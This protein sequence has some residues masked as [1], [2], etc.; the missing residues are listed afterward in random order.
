[1]ATWSVI[2]FWTG[3]GL[4]GIAAVF[5]LI[6]ALFADRPRGRRRCPKCWYD[7][8]HTP[9]LTCSECGR[10]AKR[11]K[12]L[13]KTRR[14]WMAARLSI[15]AI[16]IATGLLLTPT[17]YRTGWYEITPTTVLILLEPGLADLNQAAFDELQE[18]F[19]DDLF[20]DWQR[21]LLIGQHMDETS[22]PPWNVVI[23][24]RRDWPTDVPVYAFPRLSVRPGL[25]WLL[26]NTRVRLRHRDEQGREMMTSVWLFNPTTYW[27]G[28]VEFAVPVATARSGGERL[29]FDVLF[30]RWDPDDGEWA[31]FRTEQAAHR[32][33][34][35]GSIDDYLDK[36]EGKEV[37]ERVAAWFSCRA[38]N[39]RF[40]WRAAGPWPFGASNVMPVRIELRCNDDLVRAWDALLPRPDQEARR[41]LRYEL[42]EAKK[43]PFA[44]P[45]YES[46][47]WSVRIQGAGGAALLIDN[48]AS[49]DPLSRPF[50]REGANV[51]DVTAFWDG[52]VTIDIELIDTPEELE[53]RTANW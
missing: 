53:Y 32:M 1:M 45:E 42:Y 22:G 35:G 23:E 21:N 25:N 48:V 17:V 13:R 28:T 15:L 26:H 38:T 36:L 11:E 19:L 16:F 39:S 37:E 51:A 10:R 33:R 3:G 8:T 30:D 4:L 5:V 47:R 9:G 24:T 41:L 40:E 46:E 31:P 27:Q 18:R 12:K 52:S 49:A 50:R 2:L 20:W 43:R 7:M 14:R 29:V 44:R 34:F 6:R